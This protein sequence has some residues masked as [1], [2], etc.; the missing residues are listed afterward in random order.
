MYYAYLRYHNLFAWSYWPYRFKTFTSDCVIT[1]YVTEVM[2]PLCQFVSMVTGHD[3]ATPG[4][5]KIP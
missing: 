5:S 2:I 1:H 4:F 3:R